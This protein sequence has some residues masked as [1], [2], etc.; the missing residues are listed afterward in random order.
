MHFSWT[1]A[2]GGLAFLQQRRVSVVLGFHRLNS[3]EAVGLHQALFLR[4]KWFHALILSFLPVWFPWKCRPFRKSKA[5]HHMHRHCVLFLESTEHIPTWWC[6]QVLGGAA[7]GRYNIQLPSDRKNFM[8]TGVT[9]YLFLCKKY[10]I[11]FGKY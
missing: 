1:E 11:Y 3:D 8:S 2:C 7:E 4:T 9:G 5:L 6:E 10:E